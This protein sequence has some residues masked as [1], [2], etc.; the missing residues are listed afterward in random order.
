MKCEECG[1]S[2]MFVDAIE[3][4]VW[5]KSCGHSEEVDYKAVPEKT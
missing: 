3:D 2:L 1:S 4:V 5:C